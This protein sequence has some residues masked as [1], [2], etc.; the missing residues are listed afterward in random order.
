M[1]Y[2]SRDCFI[3]TLN[4]FK[5]EFVLL[6][7]I[8]EALIENDSLECV[9]EHIQEHR[10]Y[11]SAPSDFED[12]KK[13]D[14]KTEIRENLVKLNEIEAKRYYHFLS[15]FTD[16]H[17]EYISFHSQPFAKIALSINRQEL[18]FL[19]SLHLQLQPIKEYEDAI[20]YF[21]LKLNIY[22][23]FWKEFLE[24][25]D[26]E[27]ALESG[28]NTINEVLHIPK[29]K[30]TTTKQQVLLLHTLGIFNLPEFGKITVQQQGIL[31]GFLLNRNAKNTEDTI[32]NRFDESQFSA[33]DKQK[34]LELLQQLGIAKPE[35][36]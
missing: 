16:E 7:T 18:G 14:Y 17:T 4:G 29:Q 13:L 22:Q 19:D 23:N 30:E 6:A 2:F 27:F 11:Q 35:K 15:K 3:A 36:M 31:F 28:I 20:A 25:L 5:H 12:S 21:S 24:S 8:G 34:V 33:K 9:M 1:L 26:H 10:E 32:R